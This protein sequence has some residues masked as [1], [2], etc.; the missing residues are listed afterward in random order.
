MGL[1]MKGVTLIGVKIP[2]EDNTFSIEVPYD[3]CQHVKELNQIGKYCSECGTI[4]QTGS[5][6][7]QRM[8]IDY[9]ERC[10]KSFGSVGM[11]YYE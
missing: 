4:I 8:L 5:Y 3:N 1:D 11:V 7:E 10:E 2:L 9:N 6:S